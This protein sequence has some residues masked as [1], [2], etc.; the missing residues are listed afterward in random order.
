[1][2]NYVQHEMIL[3]EDFCVSYCFLP[4]SPRRLCRS[5]VLGFWTQGSSGL[6][7]GF[8]AHCGKDT[9]GCELAECQHQ[10]SLNVSVSIVGCFKLHESQPF[11]LRWLAAA[12]AVGITQ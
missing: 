10:V 11:A 4:P 12:N 8:R 7:Y 6:G 9:G 2:G 3:H 5:L 1:M